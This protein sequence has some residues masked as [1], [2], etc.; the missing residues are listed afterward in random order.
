MYS[1]IL[2]AFP[3]GCEWSFL[4]S[5]ILMWKLLNRNALFEEVLVPHSLQNMRRKSMIFFWNKKHPYFE[6]PLCTYIKSIKQI[7]IARNQKSETKTRKKRETFHYFDQN[8]LHKRFQQQ[9]CFIHQIHRL[10]LLSS[11]LQFIICN[12]AIFLLSGNYKRI[13]VI[14]FLAR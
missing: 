2:R 11:W 1:F 13:I 14:G 7:E 4:F 3:V 9:T 6:H 8:N 5:R 10:F 12:D